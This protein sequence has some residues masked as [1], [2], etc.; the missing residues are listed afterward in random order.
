M[1]SMQ[2]RHS[3]VLVFRLDLH[4]YDYTGTNTKISKMLR[5]LKL[6]LSNKYEMDNIGHIWVRE[7]EKAKSQH[8]HLAI[9]LN[10]H[11]IRH[12]KKVIDW[13]ENYW[14]FRNEP[15]PYTP[16]KCYT[17]VVRGKQETFD[18]AFYRLSYLAKER[19]KGYKD[20]AANNYSASRIKAP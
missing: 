12:P 14:T 11:K 7:M 17:L 15:K 1:D 5:Q 8:Y 6:W 19:G 4:V 2:S 10:G 9:M 18:E 13:I 3:R 20:R 16:K